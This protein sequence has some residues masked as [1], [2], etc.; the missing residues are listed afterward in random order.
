[1]AEGPKGFGGL[2]EGPPQDLYY[3]ATPVIARRIRRTT[4]VL[5][6]RHELADEARLAIGGR[7]DYAVNR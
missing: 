4:R 5:D 3:L 2:L 1:M 7:R 6:G